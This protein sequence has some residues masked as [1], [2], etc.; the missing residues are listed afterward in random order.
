[1][2]AGSEPAIEMA[3]AARLLDAYTAGDTERVVALITAAPLESWF[4][5]PPDRMREIIGGLPAHLIP[6]NSALRALRLFLFGPVTTAP[7][8]DL[9]LS[10][11]A[12]RFFDARARG[13]IR[14]A[15]D[16]ARRGSRATNTNALFDETAGMATFQALQVGLTE[17]LSGALAE[18]LDSF[19]RASRATP[20]AELTALLR[21]A[22]VK[23]ALV[24]ALYGDPRVARRNLD[25][26]AA[27][28]RTGSWVEFVIDAH[29]EL[30]EAAIVDDAHLATAIETVERIPVSLLGELWPFRVEA[31]FRL[32][33]RSGDLDEAAA[34]AERFRPAAA[35]FVPGRGLPGSVFAA[36]AATAALFRGD[37]GRARALLTEVD[38]FP[39]S[40]QLLRTSV[41]LASGED[42]GIIPRLV[43]MHG[44]TRDLRQLEFARQCLL[45]AALLARGDSAGAAQVLR[46]LADRA[47]GFSTWSVR[48]SRSRCPGSPP[49]RSR[50]GRRG[51]AVRSRQSTPDPLR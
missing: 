2:S 11:E 4:G 42:D 21:D 6:A 49:R 7:V 20:P 19:T 32:Q 18:S 40:Y 24:H 8:D 35:G 22:Y 14:E 34:G 30:A 10:D 27:L 15:A 29:A 26:A 12:A 23:P 45:S 39:V 47:G 13:Q 28:P 5:L 43:G 44:R 37:L 46:G 1:M 48:S 36:T 31:L 38:D 16:M 3:H 50:G 9:D 41:A 33:L 51:S 17:M 25:L